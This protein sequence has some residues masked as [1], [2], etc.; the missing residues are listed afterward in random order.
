MQRGGAAKWCGQCQDPAK[1]KVLSEVGKEQRGTPC[2]Q[3]CA[4]LCGDSG[5]ATVQLVWP[6][7]PPFLSP[8]ESGTRVSGFC[9]CLQIQG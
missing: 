6:V 9:S 7:S 1:D 2:L 3:G 8:K 4:V 5:D